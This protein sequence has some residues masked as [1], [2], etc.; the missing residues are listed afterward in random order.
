M[1]KILSVFGTR[2]EA[3]KMAPVIREILR[4]PTS[5][6]SVTCNTSQHQQMIKPVLQLFQITSDYN[7]DIMRYRQTLTDMNI[8]VLKE[9]KP[10]LRA[11]KPDWV[12][13]Q[14]DTTTAMAAALAAF[15]ERIKIGHIEAGLRTYNKYQPFPEDINRRIID[16]LS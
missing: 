3:I 10:I 11:E 13:V 12:L 16:L 2:P 4:Y 9:L 15:Y 5:I 1:I 8:A 14:G 7:L 6:A